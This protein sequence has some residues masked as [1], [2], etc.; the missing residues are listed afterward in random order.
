MAAKANFA[1]RI[2][3]LPCY[4]K[5]AGRD[6]DHLR[7]VVVHTRCS[8]DSKAAVLRGGRSLWIQNDEPSTLLGRVAR[9]WAAHT[10]RKG[11]CG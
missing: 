1:V 11:E 5:V 10:D 8:W 7:V 3:P 9:K 2:L 4:A 6:S